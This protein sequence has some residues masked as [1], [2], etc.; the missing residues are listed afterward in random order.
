MFS[1][2]NSQQ[3]QASRANQ[4]T[5]LK[6]FRDTIKHARLK[7]RMDKKILSCFVLSRDKD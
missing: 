2:D 1:V 4:Q 6:A 5:Q 3:S 7:V